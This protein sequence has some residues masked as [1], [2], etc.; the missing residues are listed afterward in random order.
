MSENTLP[1]SLILAPPNEQVFTRPDYS[2][3]YFMPLL[4]LNLS[5]VFDDLSGPIHFV[6]AVEPYDGCIGGFTQE[7]HSYY[8][9]ENWISFKVK[10]GLYD[11]EGP[12]NFFEKAYLKTHPVS[13]TVHESVRMGW[14]NAVDEH[15]V[16]TVEKYA[17]WRATALSDISATLSNH[18]IRPG[19]FGGHPHDANWSNMDSFPLAVDKVDAPGDDFPDTHSYPLTEDGRRFRYI[20]FI[21]AFNWRCAIHLFYDP[22]EQRA[23]QTFDWT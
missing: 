20:G 12:D 16:K 5:D 11:F 17:K 13:D 18:G 7:F 8:C 3:Q 6:D 21:E 15:Y 1:K 14:K 22:V 4:S 9:R 23:L 19:N 10:D 2:A